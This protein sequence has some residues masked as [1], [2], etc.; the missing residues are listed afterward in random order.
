MQQLREI[1]NFDRVGLE[2]ELKAELG[3]PPFRARQL[4]QWLHRR[5]VRDFS[6]MS[7]INSK[8]REEL[9]SRY[10]ISRPTINQ[11]QQSVDGT[12]KYLMTL[13]DGSNVE[14][15][16]IKQPKRF[17]LCVSSQVG[18]AIGCRFCKTA[19]M[20]LKRNLETHEIVGQVLAVQDDVAQLG[21]GD[22]EDGFRN[23]VFM[24]SKI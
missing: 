18:C 9:A 15:V 5:R 14:T 2:A 10:S 20:G 8:L 13:V 23:I 16:L 22:G 4:V 1:L 12:R 6:V 24:S 21:I 17:T 19:Q 7:D 11:V 3:L